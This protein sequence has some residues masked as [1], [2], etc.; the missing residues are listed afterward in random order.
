MRIEG[1]TFTDEGNPVS[2]KNFCQL[3]HVNVDNKKLSDAEFRHM[4]RNTLP[5]VDYPIPEEK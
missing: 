5:I 2:A 1:T 3:L 4:V